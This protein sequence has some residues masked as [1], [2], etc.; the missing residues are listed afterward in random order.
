[1]ATPFTVPYEG[2][3][4]TYQER[5]V[6]GMVDRDVAV[7]RGDIAQP[8]LQGLIDRGLVTVNADGI[9]EKNLEPA[10]TRTPFAGEGQRRTA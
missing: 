7:R 10:D 9:V 6:M 2:H 5:G 3:E 1:M 8:V 4:L